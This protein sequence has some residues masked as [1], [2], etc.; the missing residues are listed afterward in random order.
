MIE[1]VKGYPLLTGARGRAR[2]DIGAL[3][4][5]IM[6]VQRLALDLAGDLAE[7][8]INPLLVRKKGAI[9]LDALAVAHRR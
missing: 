2:A 5:V 3:G 6:R 9:A 7:L 4:D 8:D 1:E